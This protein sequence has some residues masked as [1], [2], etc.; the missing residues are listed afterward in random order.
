MTDSKK[1]IRLLTVIREI[2]QDNKVEVGE[3]VK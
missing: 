3:K 2:Q 1:D